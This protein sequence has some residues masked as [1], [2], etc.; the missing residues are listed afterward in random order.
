MAGN[1]SSFIHT[2]HNSSYSIKNQSKQLP[3]PRIRAPIGSLT[4]VLMISTSFLFLLHTKLH[5]TSPNTPLTSLQYTLASTLHW[6]PIFPHSLQ[7]LLTLNYFLMTFNG[8]KTKIKV[9]PRVNCYSKSIMTL[10]SI[11]DFHSCS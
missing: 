9:N 3:L 8:P 2:R 1:Q 6:S 4:L 7:F 5:S 11:L 10:L